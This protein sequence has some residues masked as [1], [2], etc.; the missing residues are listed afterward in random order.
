MK[1]PKSIADVLADMGVVY[2][3]TGD[4]NLALGHF[5]RA[6]N[7]AE[8]IEYEAL[9]ANV[10]N[11]LSII[12]AVQGYHD[13]ALLYGHDCL[14]RYGRMGDSYG[15][16]QAYNNLGTVF[17]EKRDWESALDYFEKGLIISQNIEN[18]SLMATLYIN[19]ADFNMRHADYRAAS[20]FCQL[21]SGFYQRTDEYRGMAEAERIVGLIDVEKGKFR[22]GQER[23]ENA[24]DMITKH[25]TF[26]SAAEVYRELG[27]VYRKRGFRRKAYSALH[28]SLI[29][30]ERLGAKHR[31]AIVKRELTLLRRS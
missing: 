14:A 4:C 23:L 25:G 30:F 19:K 11:S 9:M 29:R 2:Y 31:A 18:L 15:I 10:L 8:R 20:Y 16:A 5:E 6:F 24:L 12:S 3:E 13:R 27:S 1:D 22:S 17:M 21:A 26:F 28:D 7:L